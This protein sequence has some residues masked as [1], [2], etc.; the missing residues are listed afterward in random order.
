VHSTPR[1]ALSS[2]NKTISMSHSAGCTLAVLLKSRKEWRGSF[3]SVI[4]P[5]MKLDSS[6]VV[7]GETNTGIDILAH[8]G[9]YINSN[10]K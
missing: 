1:S 4:L 7:S 6:P 2:V 9:H 8:D 3:W 10:D 5:D